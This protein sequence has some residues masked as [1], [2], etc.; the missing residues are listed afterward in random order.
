M[1]AEVGAGVDVGAG[2][3]VGAG[4]DVTS[5]VD[6]AGEPSCEKTGVGAKSARSRTAIKT[7]TFDLTLQTVPSVLC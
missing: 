2:V 7:N 4:S 3:S 1:G 5:G 6:G